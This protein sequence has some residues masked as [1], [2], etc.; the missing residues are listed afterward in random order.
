MSGTWFAKVQDALKE[1]VFFWDINRLKSLLPKDA[2]ENV[3]VK[4][5][6]TNSFTGL[7]A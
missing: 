7:T 6:E 1:K 2:P 3:S 5:L 4:K